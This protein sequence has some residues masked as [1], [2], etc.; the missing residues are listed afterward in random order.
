MKPDS[1]EMVLLA[2]IVLVVVLGAIAIGYALF[3]EQ[4]HTCITTVSGA[5][6]V[7]VCHY[8]YD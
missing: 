4:P 5:V 2:I 1:F 3:G 8:G 7:T 6:H